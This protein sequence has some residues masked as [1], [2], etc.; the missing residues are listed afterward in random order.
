M[1]ITKNGTYYP[2]DY[3]KTADVPEDMKKLAESVDAQVDDIKTD[4]S[5]NN[6]YRYLESY[7]SINIRCNFNFFPIK[8]L[9]IAYF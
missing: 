9:I 1:A 4:N 6:K 5:D 8:I 2:D 7:N 3:N